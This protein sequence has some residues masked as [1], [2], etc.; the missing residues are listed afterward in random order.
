MSTETH[1]SPFGQGRQKLSPTQFIKSKLEPTPT[2]GPSE[3]HQPLDL[4]GR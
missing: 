1:V 2:A 3:Q 4:R